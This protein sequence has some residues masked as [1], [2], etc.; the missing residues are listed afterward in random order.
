MQKSLNNP[1]LIRF[2]RA[3]DKLD[4]DVGKV[5]H[6]GSPIDVAS[7]KNESMADKYMKEYLKGCFVVT[8][9]VYKVVN[10]LIDHFENIASLRYPNEKYF[11]ETIHMEWRSFS[12][13]LGIDEDQRIQPICIA[14]IS[15]AGKS[16]V[17]EYLFDLF[18]SS[19]EEVQTKSGSFEVLNWDCLSAKNHSTVTTV[20]KTSRFTLGGRR[21][22]EYSKTAYVKGLIGFGV[23]ELQF[24]TKSTTA[25]SRI[26][27]LL[28][29]LGDCLTPWFYVCNYSLLWRLLRRNDEDH[30]RI[31]PR[32]IHFKVGCGSTSQE[33]FRS[34]YQYVETLKSSISDLIS[35]EDSFS[36][37]VVLLSGGVPR[38]IRNL[39]S[40]ANGVRYRKGCERIKICHLE[41]A[42]N[43][44]EY[45]NERAKV[46]LLNHTSDFLIRRK[47]FDMV[48]PPDLEAINDATDGLDVH[49]S[50]YNKLMMAN[51]TSAERSELNRIKNRK[52]GKGR[53]FTKVISLNDVSRRSRLRAAYEESLD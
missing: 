13:R 48:F 51:L 2:Q 19:N 37:K 32:V 53:K 34:Q 52:D 17:V 47:R 8:A 22:E 25:N 9:G 24:M 50:N 49:A 39:L 16:T 43:T 11:S 42:Y 5:I 14:G 1:W 15:G 12:Q 46:E 36:E 40:I 7:A 3:R 6:I 44:S 20:L 29:G 4:D 41:T 45:A 21:L 18:G 30:A 33:I 38:N 10:E 23:D 31:I 27:N 35:N 28:M 26:T